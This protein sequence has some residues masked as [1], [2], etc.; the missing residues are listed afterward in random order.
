LE[1]FEGLLGLCGAGRQ[2]DDV[3]GVAHAFE[4]QAL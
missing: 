4:A 2:H 1:L 3:V